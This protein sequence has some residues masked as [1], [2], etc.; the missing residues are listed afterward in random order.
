MQALAA[1]T[2]TP[3][4]EGTETL[5][6]VPVTA[7]LDVLARALDG[8]DTVVAYKGG[9]RMSQVVEL[10]RERGRAAVLGTD[11]SLSDQRLFTLAERVGGGG[12]AYEEAS[13]VR[14]AAYERY[15]EGEAPYFATVLSVP[16]RTGVGGR[17]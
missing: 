3:L 4:V 16:A 9:R 6:L 17:L 7:G 5:T 10:L 15:D 2:C 14:G 13:G 1:A 8:S 11:V 12:S